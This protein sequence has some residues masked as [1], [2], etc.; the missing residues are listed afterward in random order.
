[1][2]IEHIDPANQ[3]IRPGL[4]EALEA[5]HAA[6]FLEVGRMGQEAAWAVPTLVKQLSHPQPQIRALAAR[7]LGEIGVA[8]G[9]VE[10]MLERR[11][12]DDAP[13]VRKAVRRALEQIQA[14]AADLNP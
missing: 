14:P 7:A 13:A 4:I 12:R 1:V 9:D 11:L 8:D 10:A 6:M 2:A 5:G 3:N